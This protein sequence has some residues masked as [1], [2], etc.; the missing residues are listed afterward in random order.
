[1]KIAHSPTILRK[2]LFTARLA[3]GMYE[4]E[5]QILAPI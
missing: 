3:N 1:M 2:K 5:Y 4:R